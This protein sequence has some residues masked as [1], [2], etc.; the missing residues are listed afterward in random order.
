[1]LRQALSTLVVGAILASLGACGTGGNTTGKRLVGI[2]MPQGSSDR[3]RVDG[4][5]MVEE[6]EAMGYASDLQYADDNIARQ[7]AQIDN[8]ISGNAEILIIASID[9]TKL[10]DVLAKAAAKKIPVIAYDRLI[11]DSPDV[12]CYATFDNYMVGV[13]QASFIEAGLGLSSGQG[14]FTIELFAGSPDD[15]NAYVFFDGAM[16]ILQP[17]IDAH[18]LVVRSGLT[19]IDQITTMR[20]DGDI[21]EARMASLLATSYRNVRLDAVLAP[22]DGISRG[23]ISALRF[24]GYGSPGQ[25]LPIVTGQDAELASVKSIIAGVQS[26]T[27][28]KDTRL[29]A[30][31][32]AQMSL[33]VMRGQQPTINDL[34]SYD[35]GKK[36]VPSYLLDPVS[37]DKTNYRSVLIDSGYYTETQLTT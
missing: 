21:A 14:P 12:D 33:S 23:V 31:A 34:K 28:F 9:G 13:L 35:N 25:P 29:L 10:A 15:N 19:D 11:R 37:V 20:W 32:A 22:Y 30:K 18:R 27:V 8:M 17:Y 7:I 24:A 5:S 3:W 26:Q 2:S 16:A 1:M 36:V 6:F 4:R